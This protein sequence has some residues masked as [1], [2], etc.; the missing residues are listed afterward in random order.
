M[1]LSTSIYCLQCDLYFIDVQARLE[2]IESSLS[3]PSCETCCR[4]FLNENS[5]S[6][7]MK[8][9]TTHLCSGQREEEFLDGDDVLIAWATRNLAHLSTSPKDYW[10]PQLDSDNDGTTSDSE[11]DLNLDL[12]SKTVRSYWRG[13]NQATLHLGNF[14]NSSE[15]TATCH[16]LIIAKPEAIATYSED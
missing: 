15:N 6:L 9:S 4:R 12:T 14:V 3:H 10:S 1:A 11:P 7:H 8:C 2:H 16:C 5:L 13:P